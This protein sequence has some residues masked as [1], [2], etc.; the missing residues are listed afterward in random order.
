[1][2]CSLCILTMKKFFFQ[3]LIISLLLN[4]NANSNE[5]SKNFKESMS[6]GWTQGS[7]RTEIV[8]KSEK[9]IELKEVIDVNIQKSLENKFAR[10]NRIVKVL[11]KNKIVAQRNDLNGKV[12]PAGFSMSKSVISLLIGKATCDGKI[13]LTSQA[14]IYLPELKNT[15]WGNSSV[16]DLLKMS[17]G[18]YF[19]DHS[20]HGQKNLEMRNEFAKAILGKNSK[21]HTDIFAKEDQ[22][23]FTPGTKFIYSNADTT[24]LGMLLSKATGQKINKLTNNLWNE[25]G[26]NYDARW[27]VNS[28][29]E[30]LSYMGF[31]AHPDDWLLLGQ[32]IINQKKSN[33]CFGEYL[34]EATS[35]QIENTTP[36]DN[37]GYGYQI[38]T[39]C[40]LSS[41]SYCFLGAFGQA[42]MID[43]KNEIVIYVHSVG[44]NWGGPNHWGYLNFD[45]KVK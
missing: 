11:K 6:S 3:I 5:V 45:A 40:E 9:P 38:W 34:K 1:M 42:L 20:L 26:A 30:T 44:P 12:S 7:T 36:I 14:S 10:D 4:G 24:V 18:A 28:H 15:S 23:L 2:Y 39:N 19:T 25:I 41:D 22:K 29:N 32:F 37:R 33:D 17:S 13:S 27:I 21:K 31:A 16:K 43:D 35:T 8:K